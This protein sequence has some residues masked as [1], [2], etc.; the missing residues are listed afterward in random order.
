MNL[1][2]SFFTGSGRSFFV[3]F[4]ESSSDPKPVS[5]RRHAMRIRQSRE[6]ED[7]GLTRIALFQRLIV[8]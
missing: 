8:A 5:I 6:Y 3:E 4:N 1:L 7:S 2:K